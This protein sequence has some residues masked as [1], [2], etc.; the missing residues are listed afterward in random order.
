MFPQFR[1]LFRRIFLQGRVLEW[2]AQR[3]SHLLEKAYLSQLAKVGAAEKSQRPMLPQKLPLRRILFIADCMWER[4]HLVP[5]LERIAPVTVLDLSPM[6]PGSA[7]TPASRAV[8][9]RVDSFAAACHEEFDLVLL[10]ARP[11][12]LSD[13]IFETLRAKWSCPIFGMNLDDKTQFFPTGIYS[14]PTDDYRRWSRRFD[15][16]LSSTRAAADWYAEAGGAFQFLGMGFHPQTQPKVGTGSLHELTFLGS[17]RL[18]RQRLVEQLAEYGV[19]VRTL[20]TGWATT[21][22]WV[23]DAATAFGESQINLGIGFATS[24]G[25][26]TSL[27]ARDYECPGA[28]GCYLTT[29]NW[30]LAQEFDVG[31]EI[32]CYRD[33]EELAE[34]YFWWIK[35]PDLC[36]QVAA[37]GLDRCLRSY[38]WEA[39][40][41]GVFSNTGFA[42]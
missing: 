14:D 39:R 5:S 9:V 21:A 4:D 35:R 32:L 19:R 11:A 23:Q 24:S 12:L 10:Y 41:R 20:G 1:Y 16:N 3:K 28:G 25:R 15:L 7:Q 6:K 13:A 34:M 31:K 42:S 38:T 29:F 2:W 30:E 8:F 22:G 27:K 36:R 37:A 26:L 40:F 17:R 18:E 33:V